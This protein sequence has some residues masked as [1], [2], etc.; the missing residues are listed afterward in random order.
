MITRSVCLSVLS[1]VSALCFQINT[2]PAVGGSP[3]NC[4]FSGVDRKD[5]N[6]CQISRV[7]AQRLNTTTQNCM[8]CKR[9]KVE[10]SSVAVR[11]SVCVWSSSLVLCFYS[12][13]LENASIALLKWHL[14]SAAS[15]IFCISSCSFLCS[16]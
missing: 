5:N 2:Q 7:R 10:R 8:S 9:D 1:Q 14:P 11:S 12:F 15:G 16:A 13:F 4:P 6:W 3:F